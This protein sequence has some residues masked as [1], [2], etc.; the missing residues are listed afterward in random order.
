VGEQ[1]FE[2]PSREIWLVEHGL[3]GREEGKRG[4]G[5]FR[6]A[7]PEHQARGAG[8]GRALAAGQLRE[9]RGSVGEQT[10]EPPFRDLAP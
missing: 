6:A 10:F 7:F 1:T 3:D 2:P 8:T 5:I 4:R 9:R